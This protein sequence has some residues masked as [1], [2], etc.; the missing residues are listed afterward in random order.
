MAAMAR[1]AAPM[2]HGAALHTANST[3]PPAMP[4][5]MATKVLISSSALPRERS[6]SS[7]ISGT[8][9]YLAGLKMAACSPIRKT[10]SSMPSVQPAISVVSP[11]SM[12]A[13][14]K[15]LTPI[16]T[17][18]LLTRSARWPEYP[19]KSREGRVKTAG[20]SGTYAGFALPTWRATMV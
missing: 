19:L 13:I 12:M 16:S 5:T 15:S 2:R 7:S 18:R 6:R 10:T 3:P 14:S 8:M 20:T 17:R 4:R 11:K 1:V 9:P